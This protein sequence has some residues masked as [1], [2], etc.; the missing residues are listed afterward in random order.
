MITANWRAS[1]T[2]AWSK[3]TTGAG[4][5]GHEQKWFIMRFLGTDADINISTEYA[6]FSAQNGFG[7]V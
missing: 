6:E 3:E 2:I 5:R 7:Y 4:W 1:A